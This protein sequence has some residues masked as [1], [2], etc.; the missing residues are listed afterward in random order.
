MSIKRFP[1]GTILPFPNIHEDSIPGG[2]ILCDGSSISRT[3]YSDLYS[4]IGTLYG[5][6]NSSN[7][8]NVPDLQEWFVKGVDADSMR[9]ANTGAGNIN[10]SKVN[11]QQSTY[12]YNLDLSIND[13]EYTDSEG[14][15]ESSSIASP[16][17]GV[18]S[19]LSGQ[20]THTFS[21]NVHE[22][23]FGAGIGGDDY[24]QQC[25]DNL[26]PKNYLASDRENVSYGNQQYY[27]G[28]IYC[29]DQSLQKTISNFF[30]YHKS[31]PS[32]YDNKWTHSDES[33]V[34]SYYCRRG[35]MLWKLQEINYDGPVTVDVCRSPVTEC[36]WTE[37][38]EEDPDNDE[39][40]YPYFLKVG[41]QSWVKHGKFQDHSSSSDDRAKH[42][43]IISREFQVQVGPK[44]EDGGTYD[45]NYSSKRL[46]TVRDNHDHDKLM[47][48]HLDENG[49]VIP[50]SDPLSGVF[51]GSSEHQVTSSITSSIEVA[52]NP[53][54]DESY[55][56]SETL[57][58]AIVMAFIIKT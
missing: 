47:I 33:D 24:S 15:V 20:H 1:T 35:G 18:E 38:P 21:L 46:F 11:F 6:G 40:Y 44:V 31:N 39:D 48:E 14:E 54:T 42:K 43:H 23:K 4:L 50:N 41:A 16:E 3:T 49:I 26:L 2:W 7:E 5:S 57:P 19:T 30:G 22:G 27:L 13:S 58:K 25:L 52:D 55:S 8:F 53:D 36:P 56:G 51:H 12:S 28:K 9:D 17:S 32:E 29:T 34:Y 10:S 45:Y 37:R